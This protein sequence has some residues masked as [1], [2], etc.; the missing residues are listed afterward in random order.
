MANAVNITDLTRAAKQYDNVLRELPYFQF[1]EVAKKLRI[2]IQKVQGEHI[3]ISKRRKADFLRPYSAGLTLGQ[4]KELLKFFEAKL[5]PETVY[6]EINDNILSYKDKMVISNAGEPVD[7]KS[8]KHPLELLILRDLVLS[9][10]EDVIFNMFHAIRDTDTASAATSFNG[11]FS[12]IVALTT[13]GEID[14]AKGNLKTTG[15]FAQPST[16]IDTSYVNYT[17]LVA[18]IK[19][20]HPLLRRG[21]VILYA[22]ENPLTQAR[23]DFRKMVKTFEYPSLVQM[24]ERIRSDANCP[25]LK[26]ITDESFGSGDQL[27]LTKPGNF[28]FGVGEETDSSYVQ[29]RNPHLDPNIVQ[30]WIQA[31][32]DTRIQDVHEKLF[33]TNEQ[34]NTSLNYAGDYVDPVEVDPV[35]EDDDDGGE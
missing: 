20:A 1:M 17:G 5:K 13:A 31:A 21:E 9:V 25:G 7:N 3:L 32:Y 28:D 16:G 27:I 4:E 23:T 29:V 8:K 12:K 2:N 24:E 34:K 19:S 6:A 14:A 10:G 22:A 18:F 26:I 35:E 30:F 33:M 15:A 11:F